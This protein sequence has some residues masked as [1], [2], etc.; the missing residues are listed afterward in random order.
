MRG[1]MVLGGLTCLFVVA[2]CERS[3]QVQGDEAGVVSV[4]PTSAAPASQADVPLPFA[5]R[6]RVSPGVD[7]I[8]L[9]G[10]PMLPAYRTR[11]A[12]LKGDANDDI[13]GLNPERFAITAPPKHG[14]RPMVEWEPMRSIILSVPA[15]MAQ[16]T[17]AWATLTSI[18][19]H[20]AK[21]AEVW[22]IV[23]AESVATNLTNSLINMGMPVTDIATKVKFLVQPL[24]SVWVIDSGPLPIVDPETNTFAFLDFRYYPD[25]PFDDGNPSWLGRQV[26]ALGL[27]AAIN[28][29]RPALSVEG[30]TFQA[31]EDGLC[32]TGNRQ[33]YHMSCSEPGGCDQSIRTMPL[34]EVQEHPL[35]LKIEEIW[36]EYA[37]CVDTVITNSITD[38]G[39]GHI[40]MYLKVL[41][42]NR[43]LIG[44]YEAPFEGK[45][46]ENAARMD[47]N[48]EFLANYVKP[49]GGSFTVERIKMPGHRTVQD[50]AENS[51]MPFTYINSTFIN[52]LNLWPAF[53]FPEWEESRTLAESEWQS[54]LPDVEHIWIDSEELSFWS[55]AIHC[56]TR[57][58]PAVTP[59]TWVP[60]GTCDDCGQC[61]AP[62]GGY[63]DMCRPGSAQEDVCYGP[64]WL[65]NCNDCD[66]PCPG[67]TSDTAPTSD[68]CQGIPKGGCCNSGANLVYCDAGALSTIN[69]QDQ[70]C[71]WNVEKGWYDCTHEGEDPSGEA[72]LSCDALQEAYAAC[73]PNCAGKACGDDGCGGTCGGC[74]ECDMCFAGD[75]VPACEDACEIGT[76]GCE[77]S[78]Q[79]A[80]AAGVAGCGER[81]ETDCAGSQQVCSAGLCVAPTV[82]GSGTGDGASDGEGSGETGDGSE[83][84][85]GDS[86][87][88]SGVDEG[89]GAEGG[90]AESGGCNAS[91]KTSGPFGIALMFLGVALLLGVRRPQ[92]AERAQTVAPLVQR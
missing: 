33:I 80:C 66:S 83:A 31:T 41:D 4:S 19:F 3:P 56:V 6:S 60:D 52:G 84:N 68:P 91:E 86:G 42:T 40:D 27:E 20:S 74:S 48:A 51:A 67:D 39:T 29:Y 64:E 49:D 77:G 79:W 10:E 90:G 12:P 44:Y 88:S 9:V 8:K 16:Y 53:S 81:F 30:G 70:G 57:T 46:E 58:V 50:G 22:Y 34:D 45:A 25:R 54:A 82:D 75:C 43:V 21:V 1:W 92:W 7:Y 11:F 76:L 35:T 63:D 61:E 5:E 71:G 36:R 15:Y 26:E 59:S 23:S 17:N 13:R 85:G 73:V 69:C 38:D 18:G 62:E 87:N 2:G 89:G 24:D 47:A 72:A 78:I 65:C 55:G 14:V 28:T 37:G 32:I